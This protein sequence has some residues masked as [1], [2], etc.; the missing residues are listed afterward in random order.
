MAEHLPIHD[1]RNEIIAAVNS[2][3]VVIVKAETGAG[4]STQVPQF[5]LE[6]AKNVVVTQP[7]RLAAT[8]IAQRVAE[9]MEC[10]IGTVVGYRFSGE[11]KSTPETRILYCTDGLELVRQLVGGEHPEG[12]LVI[13]ELHEW[14]LNIELLVAWVR[15]QLDRGARYK[16][17]VMSATIEPEKL[18]EYFDDAVVIEVPGRSFPVKELF[19][20]RAGVVEDAAK[21]IA[22]GHNVLVFQPGK[23]EIEETVTA[24]VEMGVDAEVFPLHAEM[25]LIDQM[26][27]FLSYRRPKCIVATNVAQTSITIPDIDA[28]VDSGLERRVEYVNGVEGLY[29]RPISLADRAQRKGRAGRTKPGIYVDACQMGPKAREIFPKADIIRLPMDKVFLQLALVGIEAEHLRFFNQPKLEHIKH[30]RDMLYSLGCLDDKGRLTRIGEKVATLPVSTRF[31]RM[32]VEAEKRN[33]LA[34]MITLVSLMEQG[35]ITTTRNGR[36]KKMVEVSNW[37]DAFAEL[38]AYE[39]ALNLSPDRLEEHGIDSEAFAKARDM[40]HRLF[41]ALQRSMKIGRSTGREREIVRSLYTGLADCLYKKSLVKGYK[42]KSGELRDLPK[43]SVVA[44]AKWVVGLPW[45]LQVRSDFGP[46]TIRLIT[47]ATRVD[48][49]LLVETV[50]HL[51]TIEEKGNYLRLHFDGMFLLEQRKQA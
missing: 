41:G 9:E 6:C 37:S 28:V 24:L 49:R 5:L 25:P 10:E 47:M 35:G 33:V 36:W 11:D 43:E 21:L 50:R 22:K 23:T 39:A 2:H 8:A 31:G 48:A 40:R 13:D 27:C 16:V 17:V 20:S 46:K 45:N 34:D 32:L 19:S 30:A 3:R 4:K 7:R 1:Y 42:D 18:V 12:V 29:I 44:D 15:Y 38:S 51:A 26:P 14:N